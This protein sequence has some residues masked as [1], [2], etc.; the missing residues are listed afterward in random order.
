MRPYPAAPVANDSSGDSKLE[1][2]AMRTV[3]TLDL[4]GDTTGGGSDGT[5]GAGTKL[6][7]SGDLG[8][9]G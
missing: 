2:P 9:V 7:A 6:G 4:F 5:P 8:S 1:E 3:K